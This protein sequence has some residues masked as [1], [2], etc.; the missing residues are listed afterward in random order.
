MDRCLP[1]GASSVIQ[2]GT[3]KSGGQEDRDGELGESTAKC[4]GQ[5]GHDSEMRES[6][7]EQTMDEA[8]M[9]S[10]D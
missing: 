4:G 10:N 8:T 3:G 2:Q 6:N 7:A 9:C 5:E 1:R